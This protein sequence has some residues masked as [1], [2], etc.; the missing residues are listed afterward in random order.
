MHRLAGIPVEPVFITGPHR[1]GTTLL[2]SLLLASQRF[3]GVTAYHVLRNRQILAHHLAGDTERA[4]FEL[5]EEFR[6]AGVFDRVIDGVRVTPDMPEE[7]G[8]LLA[9]PGPPR[10]RPAN[11]K[12]FVDL[13]RKVQFTGA[14]G[15][16]LLLKNPWDFGRSRFAKQ[17]FPRSRFLFLHREPTRTL[18]SHLNAARL[19]L[20]A[21]NAYLAMLV[22]KYGLLFRRPLMLYPARWLFAPG[23]TLGARLLARGLAAGIESAARDRAELPRADCFDVRYEDLCARPNE[24]IAAIL[25][26]LGLGD[27][28][29]PDLSTM[30]AP[31]G[32]KLLPEVER[33]RPMFAA[34]LSD[35][36]REF[37]YSAGL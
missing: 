22:P 29:I 36:Y 33:L 11:L 3:N 28:G 6:A 25:G 9:N 23:H 26:W 17:H 12:R 15:R 24:T 14:P 37:G 19:M 2:Y 21:R 7:Y 32:G 27:S 10:L 5:A 18:N 8:F 35:Y 1:S 20:A 13:C 30:I 4:K 31:R 34:R 16:P